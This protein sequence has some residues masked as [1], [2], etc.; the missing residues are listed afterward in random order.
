MKCD[1]C[2]AC[3]SHSYEEGE[4]DFGCNIGITDNDR[5]EFKDLSLGCRTPYN[6]TLFTV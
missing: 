4:P 3:Y 1:N 5:V 2:P 6:K